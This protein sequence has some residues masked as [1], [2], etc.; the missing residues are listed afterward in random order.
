MP[1]SRLSRSLAVVGLLQTGFLR[2]RAEV[3]HV[4][5][6]WRAQ[7]LGHSGELPN[8]Q[9]ASSSGSGG[10]EA[11]QAVGGLRFSMGARP[12]SS[13]GDLRSS[14]AAAAR[15][16][17]SGGGSGEQPPLGGSHPPGSPSTSGRGGG[18]ADPLVL[19]RDG[20]HARSESLGSDT[21]LQ[22]RT[23]APFRVPSGLSPSTLSLQ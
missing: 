22:A 6:W 10:G 3:C 1:F 2:Q 20:A 11:L 9:G 13:S 14:E 5:A 17:G 23:L 21:H 16:S 8:G 4:L 19:S 15:R 7:A 12:G 18:G